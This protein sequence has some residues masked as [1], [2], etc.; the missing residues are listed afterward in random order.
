MRRFFYG[1]Q[2]IRNAAENYKKKMRIFWFGQY[3]V[4]DVNSYEM[5]CNK[6]S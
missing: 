3:M 4:N 1:A 2:S 5:L 6:I